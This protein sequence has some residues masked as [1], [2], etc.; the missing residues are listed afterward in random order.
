M[1][2]QTLYDNFSQ[3]R[4]YID[5]EK[6]DLSSYVTKSELSN[7]GYL[8]SIPSEYI[9]QQELS[10]NSYATT[11]ELSSYL[12]LS[13]G[14]LNGNLTLGNTY[15]LTVGTQRAW[16]LFEDGSGSGAYIC[17]QAGVD[18]KSFRVR[19][20]AGNDL[21]HIYESSNNPAKSEIVHY[22]NNTYTCSIIPRTDNTYTLGSH[23]LTRYFQSAYT[24]RVYLGNQIRLV[25]D[26][27]NGS[28][29]AIYQG[30]VGHYS[31]ETQSFHPY[32]ATYGGN[33]D[34]GS[35]TRTWRSTYTNNLYLNGN[36]IIDT[37]NGIFSY[38]STTGTLS[39]TT[40]S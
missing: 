16:K 6:P 21:L 40:I 24:H 13:G 36:N 35:S 2:N 10:G 7:C 12:P 22:T 17:L 5:Q 3:V 9:T 1:P 28:T 34:L 30:G 38:D 32:G 23:S 19:D 26:S 15:F 4:Q 8:T 31:F 37:I 27:G 18:S 14:T 20:M 25:D 33:I 11:S 39:I 29:F